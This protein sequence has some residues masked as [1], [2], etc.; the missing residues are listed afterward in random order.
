MKGSRENGNWVGVDWGESEHHVSVVD[1]NRQVKKRFHVPH[2]PKGMS[3]LDDT[4]RTFQP[5]LGIAIE[6]SRNLLITHLL[7]QGYTVYFINPKL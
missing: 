7:A 2:S 4:L 6:S 5:I 1:T 3:T